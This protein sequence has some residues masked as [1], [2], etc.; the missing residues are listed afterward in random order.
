MAPT[1]KQKQKKGFMT[2][3]QLRK[4]FDHI[5]SFTLGLLSRVKEPATQRK[6]F[7]QEW[8]KVF[9]R[10]V[11]DK[12]AD[13]YLKFESKKGK[14]KRGKTRKMKGGAQ[15]LAGAPLD[16]STRPGLHGP[17]GTFPDYISG[18]FVV[19]NKFNNMAIQE[20]CNAPTKFQPPYTGF[21]ATSQKGGRRNSRKMGGGGNFPS[22]SEFATAFSMRPIT[23]GATP[24]MEYDAQMSWKG[25]GASPSSQ[26]NTGTPGY[27]GYEPTILQA[28]ATPLTRNLGA[29]LGV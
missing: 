12:A 5:E 7:Q 17:Y 23:A 19:G 11:D 2:I 3:P 1:R 21:G 28:N 26:P 10:D 14:G 13:A 25:A 20:D 15:A 6:A 29:E 22:I 18:G 9:H 8:R 16:Y 24:S 27:R 4:S